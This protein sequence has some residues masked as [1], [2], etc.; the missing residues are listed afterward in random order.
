M[1]ADPG[2][3]RCRAR[4]CR[5]HGRE[6]DRSCA[7]RRDVP[8]RNPWRRAYRRLLGWG[9]ADARRAIARQ[10]ESPPVLPSCAP[11]LTSDRVVNRAK[12][13]APQQVPQLGFHLSD[14][15]RSLVDEAGVKLDQARAGLDMAER[16]VG[17]RDAANADDRQLAA[18]MAI[19]RRDQL[20]RE[21]QQR[22][23]AE[24]ALVIASHPG[25]R[26]LERGVAHDDAVEAQL[27]RGV[28]D[29]KQRGLI[30]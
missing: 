29:R 11:R 15:S 9:R 13:L 14:E 1:R 8:P 16:V 5:T 12:T 25:L 20:A 30:E 24:P 4:C 21:R 18:S 10:P 27:D 28:A 19:D 2:T 6:T 26:A 3:R 22:L 17:A 7:R 23:A